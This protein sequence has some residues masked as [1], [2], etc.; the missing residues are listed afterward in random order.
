MRNTFFLPIE[1][2]QYGEDRCHSA[3]SNLCSRCSVSGRTVGGNGGNAILAA[4]GGGIGG[5]IG[6]SDCRHGASGTAAGGGGGIA[7]G[8]ECIACTGTG[9]GGGKMLPR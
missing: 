6:K 9:G 1:T 4:G 7:A 8:P 5:G 3:A 2:A